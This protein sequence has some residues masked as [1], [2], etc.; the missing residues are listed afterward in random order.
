MKVLNKR[1]TNKRP[2]SGTQTLFCPHPPLPPR[3]RPHLRQTTG[4]RLLVGLCPPGTVAGTR[5]MTSGFETTL[6]SFGQG[7]G[8]GGVM[9]LLADTSTAPFSEGSAPG[10][11]CPPCR[12][13]RRRRTEL[14]PQPL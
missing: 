11:T 7:E 13:R 4:L 10:S 12:P 14:R 2:I 6:T 9:G 1:S 3:G 8:G 5:A